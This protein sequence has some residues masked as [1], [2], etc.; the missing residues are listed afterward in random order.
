MCQISKGKFGGKKMRERKRKEKENQVIFSDRQK[1]FK[2][3]NEF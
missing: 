2:G 1:I 3:K